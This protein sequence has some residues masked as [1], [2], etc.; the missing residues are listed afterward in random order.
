M[1]N[2]GMKINILKIKVLECTK[3][4]AIMVAIYCYSG[5]D[6]DKV[7]KFHKNKLSTTMVA[8]YCYS[9]E[10]KDKVLKF[11]KKNSSYFEIS[12]TLF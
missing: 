3:L 5:E 8:I 9:R 10:D 6:K 4:S 7:L 11:H 1:N 12:T 2:K